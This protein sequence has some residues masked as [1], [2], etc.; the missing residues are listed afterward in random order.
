MRTGRY[1]T[2]IDVGN[3]SIPVFNDLDGDGDFDLLLA[4]KID[5][6]NL[7]SSQ[8]YRFENQGT[9]REPSFRLTGTL[10]LAGSYHYAPVFGDLDGDGD[11]DMLLGSWSDDVAYYRNVGTATEPRF[12]VEDSAVV[13]LTRGSNRSMGTSI[14]YLPTRST[15]PICDRP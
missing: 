2:G 9:A 4:N 3:E 15:L 8:V 7:R 13:S 12:V 6:A 1:L 14:C 10:D 11:L 5:P